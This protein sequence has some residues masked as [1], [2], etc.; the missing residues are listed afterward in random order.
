[1]YNSSPGKNMTYVEAIKSGF[2]LINERWQLVAIQAGMMI[3]NCIGF[4]VIVGIPLGIAFVLFGLDLTGLAESRNIIDVL[5]NPLELLSKYMGFVIII[6]LSFLVYLL[7]ATIIG[8]YVFGGSIGIIGRGIQEPSLKFGIRSFFREAKRLFFPLMWFSLVMGLIFI[9]IAF[10][11]GLFGGGIAALVQVL[12]SQDSTLGLFIG[13]FLALLL[14]LFAIGMILIALAVAVY[15]IAALF[16]K[17]T[18]AFRSVRES[19]LF[20]WDNQNAF[21]LYMLLF[22]AYIL[23]SFVFMLISYPFNLIP[24]IG[25][26]ISFPLQLVLYIVQSYLGLVII[27]TIFIYY[28][29]FEFGNGAYP[30]TA[31]DVSASG[32]TGPSDISPGGDPLQAGPPPPEEPKQGG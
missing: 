20:L 30:G 32:S 1:M 14:A 9:V 18:G 26:I 23:A 12:K 17:G 7:I 4:F 6:V 24:I 29:S 19:A 22:M 11:L 15:G 21:W 13:I 10:I 25:T 8:I 31:E 16:F 5:R 2:N 28:S 27:A 3:A